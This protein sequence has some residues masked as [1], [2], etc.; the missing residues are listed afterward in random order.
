MSEEQ[1]QALE[2]P[3]SPGWW[4][5]E[6]DRDASGPLGQTLQLVVEVFDWREKLYARFP[7]SGSVAVEHVP[8]KWVK[9]VLPWESQAQGTGDEVTP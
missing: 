4:A 2:M 1:P 7:M 9:L 8:G 5:F 3:D 6:G